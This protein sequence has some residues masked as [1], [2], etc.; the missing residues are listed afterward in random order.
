M[1]Q[2]MVIGRSGGFRK[3]KSVVLERKSSV[4]INDWH[5]HQTSLP[6]TPDREKSP[7]GS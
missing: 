5:S 1:S 3:W 4:R 7:L 6:V 2:G